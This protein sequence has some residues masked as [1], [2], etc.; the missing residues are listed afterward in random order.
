M[1]LA[2]RHL[3]KAPG[4]SLAAIV[5]L[6]LAIGATTAIFSAVHA[7]LLNPLPAARA[8]RLV[9]GWGFDPERSQGLIELTYRDIEALGQGN[10]SLS[11]VS[12]VGASTWTA[13]LEGHGEPARLSYAGVS[14]MFFETLRVT[15]ALGRTLAPEDDVPN[16]PNVI[17]LSHG[18]WIRRFGSDPGIVGRMLR[19]DDESHEVVGVMPAGFEYPKGAE[20]WAPL[21]PGLSRASAAWKTDVLANVGVLFFVGRLH[22]DVTPAM[23]AEDLTAA[24]RR[25]DEGRPAPM[26]GRQVVVVPFLDHLIGPARQAIWALFGAVGLLLLIACANVSGLMLTRVA[27]RRRDHAIRLA[28]GA[29]RASIGRQWAVETLALTAAGGGAGL[30]LAHW[31]TAAIVGL[32]PDGIPKL[33]QVAVNLP[34]AGFAFMTMTLTAL[35]CGVGPARHA[36]RVALVDALGDG[37]RAMSAAQ[38]VRTRSVLLVLQMGLAVVLLV[39]AGLVVRSFSA[40][41]Q[42]ELGFRPESVLTVQIDPRVEQPPVNEWMRE[43]IA[44]VEAHTD[45]E[46]VGAVYLRPLALGPI[47]QGTQVWLRGQPET[48]EAAAAN[49]VLNYQSATPG[50][51]LAMRIPLKRGRYFTDDDD[52]PSARVAIV[53][54][55]T[56]ERLWPGEDPIGMPFTTSTFDRTEGAPRLAQRTVVGVVSDVRYRGIDEVQYDMYDP[57]AQTPMGATDLVIRTRGSPLALAGVVQTY[58]RDLSPRVLVSGI[59]TMDAIVSAAVAPWRFSAW[60]FSLFAVLA[61]TLAMVGLFSLVSLDVA[62]R[63]QEFAI[64]MAL[65]ASRRHITRRV[66]AASFARGLAGLTVG[67]L[68]AA[69][70]TTLLESLLFG[71]SLLDW[72]T[73]LGVVGLVGAVVAVASYLPVRAA[74][75]ADPAVLLRRE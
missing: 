70:S 53:S 42:I 38:S 49:P 44:R 1:A 17:V 54:E 26:I 51:F 52:R 59:T 31:L 28:I 6:A 73:Y 34:V 11:S 58:A 25:L 5:T 46:A 27:L 22:D 57:A 50:Y 15:P 47:G 69:A 29:T 64:R 62:H 23:A 2:L 9:I 13:V 3:L 35:L 74:A 39:A 8:D 24:G 75:G 43:L 21:A 40:L 61:F 65:G 20:Y 67:L 63:T 37:G 71:V 60:V 48:A 12:S 66:L 55:S 68:A 32:A 36:G 4:Y 56:A 30:V 19:L 33:D 14:G 41:R 18:A 72:P 7:V 10:R 16:G 45:V